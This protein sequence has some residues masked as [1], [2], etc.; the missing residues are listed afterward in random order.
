MRRSTFHLKYNLKNVTNILKPTVF[1]RLEQVDANI[2]INKTKLTKQK[3]DAEEYKCEQ[4]KIDIPTQAELKKISFQ[5][6][7]PE[8][9]DI[10]RNLREFSRALRE[11]LNFLLFC[12]ISHKIKK[13][14]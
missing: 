1:E 7:F 8:N 14:K 6:Y 11:L 5:S 12:K 3:C 2:K 13:N 9:T 4:I 10:F